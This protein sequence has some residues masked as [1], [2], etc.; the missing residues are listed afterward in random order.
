MHHL[1]C[2]AWLDFFGVVT[3]PTAEQ[4]PGAE[5]QMFRDEEPQAEEG[6]GDF[7]GKQL[8][9]VTFQAEGIGGFFF[10]TL[11]CAVGGDRRDYL[12]WVGCVEF[13]FEGRNRR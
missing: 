9:N 11:F 10:D 5:P 12:L 3:G 2:Q 6:A 8:A 1:Q 7:V 4:V 13:F